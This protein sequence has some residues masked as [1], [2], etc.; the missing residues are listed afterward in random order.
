MC[1]WGCS[2][3]WWLTKCHQ[4]VVANFEL[5]NNVN[6]Y[7]F[8]KIVEGTETGRDHFLDDFYPLQFHYRFSSVRGEMIAFQIIQLVEEEIFANVIENNANHA[9]FHLILFYSIDSISIPTIVNL[10]A[11]PSEVQMLVGDNCERNFQRYLIV[12]NVIFL[13]SRLIFLVNGVQ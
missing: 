8:L 10:A 1:W 4:L 6:C 11:W 13:N 7:L 3:W 5:S 2:T 12:F 9:M